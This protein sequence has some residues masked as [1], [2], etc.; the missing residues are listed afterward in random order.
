ML[1][2]KDG[3]IGNQIAFC[4][5][6]TMIGI[7]CEWRMTWTKTSDDGFDFVNEEKLA[8]GSWAY[9]DEWRYRRA[10]LYK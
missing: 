7:D 9:I 6:M 2:S 3:W 10:V 8:D 1:R 5:L 4:G